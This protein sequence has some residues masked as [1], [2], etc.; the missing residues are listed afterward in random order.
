MASSNT[1]ILDLDHV[2][3]KF[4]TKVVHSNITLSL[5]NHGVHAIIGESGCGKSV[6]LREIIGLLRPTQGK[7]RLLGE[8]V[9]EISEAEIM[10]LRS[11]YAVLFQDSALFSSLTVAENVAAPIKERLTLPENWL[12][13]L[14]DLKLHLSGLDSKHRNKL[15]SE[16]S[17]GMRKRAALARALALDPEILFLDEPTSGLDPITSRMFDQVIRTLVDGLQL[18]V[19]LITHDID[20]ILGIVDNLVVLGGSGTVL[21]EGPVREV[22]SLPH[23]WIQRYFSSRT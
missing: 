15:P 7:I 21:A 3:T 9:W 19:L 12:S 17:G 18:T 11:R 14:V 20:T 23:P 5:R 10:E 13:E 16:L 6:L 22:M 2:Q 4:G 1:P 8:S